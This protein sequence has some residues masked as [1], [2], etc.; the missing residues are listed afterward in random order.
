MLKLLTAVWF[1]L[2]DKRGVAELFDLG[3]LAKIY[4][5]SFTKVSTFRQKWDQI[6]FFSRLSLKL[7]ELD[8]IKLQPYSS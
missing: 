4:A 8:T 3:F 1:I 6:S 2:E 5:K 7:L